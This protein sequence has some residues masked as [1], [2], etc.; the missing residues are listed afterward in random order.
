[1]RRQ[2]RHRDQLIVVAKIFA[3][4]EFQ[5]VGQLADA[6]DSHSTRRLSVAPQD[7]RD[8][9][10]GLKVREPCR[11]GIASDRAFFEYDYSENRLHR[12]LSLAVLRWS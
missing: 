9:L 10:L 1:M 11:R 4:E 8:D 5:F 2:I 6:V 12:Y 3:V 7:R